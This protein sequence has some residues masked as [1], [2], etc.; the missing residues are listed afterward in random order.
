MNDIVIASKDQLSGVEMINT[1][2][3]QLTSITNENSASAEEMSASAEE[4]S[5]QAEHL[6]G[7]ISGFNIDTDKNNVGEIKRDIKKTKHF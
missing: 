3:N 4:L 6:N 5:A 2:I 1:S 7:L